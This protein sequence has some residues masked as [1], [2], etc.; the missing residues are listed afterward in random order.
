MALLETLALM[1]ISEVPSLEILNHW[2]VNSLCWAP[3]AVCDSLP[4]RWWCR[5][6]LCCGPVPGGK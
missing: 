6:M 2:M 1:A 3:V 4:W 5:S